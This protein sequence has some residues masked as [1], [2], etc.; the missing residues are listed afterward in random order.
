MSTH[1]CTSRCS[2]G[3][4]FLQCLS[5]SCLVIFEPLTVAVP[6]LLINCHCEWIWHS[7]VSPSQ[8]FFCQRTILYFVIIALSISKFQRDSDSI[9]KNF[10]VWKFAK[11]HGARRIEPINVILPQNTTKSMCRCVLGRALS[12]LLGVR[13]VKKVQQRQSWMILVR[14][15][16][17]TLIVGQ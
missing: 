5:D 15:S 9:Q 12:M 14:P 13:S 7:K 3:R 8:P 1:F 6:Q 2:V 10:S 11:G 17:T 16:Q 4:A